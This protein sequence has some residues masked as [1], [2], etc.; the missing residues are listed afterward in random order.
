MRSGMFFFAGILA[1][2]T[3]Q[4]LV[5]QGPVITG[6]NHVGIAVPDVIATANFYTSKLGCREA[7]RNTNAQGRTTAIYLQISRDTFL[8]L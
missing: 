2:V 8:E 5:A 3:V 1:A 7:F 4:G 6:L